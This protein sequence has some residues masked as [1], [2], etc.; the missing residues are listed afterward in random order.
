VEHRRYAAARPCQGPALVKTS[1]VDGYKT[2]TM[3]TRPHAA[4]TSCRQQNPPDRDSR[5]STAG[6][7][8]NAP[9]YSTSTSGCST[10]TPYAPMI[11]SSAPTRRAGVRACHHIHANVPAGP[12]RAQLVEH[13][14]VRSGTL[15]HLAAYDVHSA[16]VFGR[17]EPSTGIVPFNARLDRVMTI[18]PCASAGRVFWIVDIGSS[19][20]GWT[21]A[22]RPNDAYPTLHDPP[23]GTRVLAQP[24]RD[25]LLSRPTQATHQTSWTTS[26]PSPNASQ[27]SNSAT[28]RVSWHILDLL[29]IVVQIDKMPTYNQRIKTAG[30]SRSYCVAGRLDDRLMTVE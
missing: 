11:T 25:L 30:N 5:S 7:R 26:P 15:A 13:E 28:T 9:A 23:A 6:G 29:S 1:V 3:G 21:A 18:E 8:S 2:T 4:S 12:D 16:R 22:K 10:A 19:H 24:G 14:Y 20:N 27:P 17:S